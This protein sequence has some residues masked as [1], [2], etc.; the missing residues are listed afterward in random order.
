MHQTDIG[1][2]KSGEGRNWR[3]WHLS[4]GSE[5][6]SVRERYIRVAAVA[7]ATAEGGWRICRRKT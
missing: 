1:H 4:V 5:V 3:K 6:E 2:R 7:I